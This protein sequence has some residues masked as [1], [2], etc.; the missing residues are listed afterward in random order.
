MAV[1]E[2]QLPLTPLHPA[3]RLLFGAAAAEVLLAVVHEGERV[4]LH[5]RPAVAQ[6]RRVLRQFREDRVRPDA[7][8]PVLAVAE[9]RLAAVRNR[10]PSCGSAAQLDTG[11]TSRTAGDGTGQAVA[12]EGCP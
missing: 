10:L 3:A 1:V 6:P 2:Q 12:W 4:P 5:P 9:V 11:P 7:P 8:E